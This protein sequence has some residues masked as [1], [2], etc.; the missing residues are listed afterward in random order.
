M[1]DA[2]VRVPDWMRDP[3]QE[4]ATGDAPTLPDFEQYVSYEDEDGTLIC[5]SKNPSAW[6]RSDAV[7]PIRR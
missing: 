1:Y 7:T 4:Q 6:I 2:T 5:D 3:L